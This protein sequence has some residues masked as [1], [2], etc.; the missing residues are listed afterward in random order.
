MI[1]RCMFIALEVSIG[2]LNSTQPG[3]LR[4]GSNINTPGPTTPFPDNLNP[5]LPPRTSRPAPEMIR[6]CMFIALE[7]SVGQLNSTQTAMLRKGSN[8]NTPGPT[9]PFPDNRN[10]P[11]PPSSQN[12]TTVTSVFMTCN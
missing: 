5:P 7:V 11:L 2:Q 9:T 1:R 3:K 4:K 12:I 10:L 6:L 8:I